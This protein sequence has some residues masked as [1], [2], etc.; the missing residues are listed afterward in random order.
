MSENCAGLLKQSQRDRLT[1]KAVGDAGLEEKRI[2]TG[3]CKRGFDGHALLQK[4]GRNG[5][6]LL[7]VA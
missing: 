4:L 7:L 5:L 6:N 1:G 2:K 3:L